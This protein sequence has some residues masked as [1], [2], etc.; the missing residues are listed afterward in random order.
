MSQSGAISATRQSKIQR[1]ET[2]I[3]DKTLPTKREGVG[4][5]GDVTVKLLLDNLPIDERFL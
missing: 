1:L 2:L 3:E 5:K 4:V